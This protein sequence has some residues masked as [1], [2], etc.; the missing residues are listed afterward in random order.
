[1]LLLIGVPRVKSAADGLAL[2]V[3]CMTIVGARFRTQDYIDQRD[4]IHLL[5]YASLH[6]TEKIFDEDD[7]A[8]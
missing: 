5:R 8:H 4:R 3:L 1:M 6:R 7:A 2:A